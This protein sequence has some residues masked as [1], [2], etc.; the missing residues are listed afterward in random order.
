MARVQFIIDTMLD[1]KT[2]LATDFFANAP[3]TKAQL[4]SF[5]KNVLGVDF[6]K[7]GKKTVNGWQFEREFA[8]DQAA[9]GKALIKNLKEAKTEIAA[10]GIER[11]FVGLD[12]DYMR[13]SIYG[14]SKPVR[15]T[16]FQVE[17]PPD[18]KPYLPTR[19]PKTG[20][21]A[22]V[23]AYKAPKG[24]WEEESNGPVTPSTGGE[25]QDGVIV[26][27][28]IDSNFNNATQEFLSR[29][30]GG[31]DLMKYLLAGEGINSRPV[32]DRSGSAQ[33]EVQRKVKK[34][35]APKEYREYLLRNY[36]GTSM[37]KKLK[38][39]PLAVTDWGLRYVE[40]EPDYY[41]YIFTFEVGK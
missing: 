35:M 30:A 31:R 4:D 21:K 12:K 14:T 39:G 10:E 38:S 24:A 26:V 25:W 29:N 1:S 15:S 41:H 13:V 2:I 11:I 3:H 16:K 27:K 33:V 40:E 5:I 18:W 32:F 6:L 23:A 17:P 19:V 9:V 36:V 7:E 8:I 20:G 28:A 22:S 34:A 37:E